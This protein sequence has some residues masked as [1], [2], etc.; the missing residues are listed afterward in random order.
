MNSPAGRSGHFRRP[1]AR[2]SRPSLE[3]A[4][5]GA[6]RWS[7][8]LPQASPLWRSSR[9]SGQPPSRTS[10]PSTTCA[11]RCRWCRA[12]RLRQRRPRRH[13]RRPSR[14]RLLRRRLLR[15][16]LFRRRCHLRR[17]WW[18][19]LRRRLQHPRRCRRRRIGDGS[20]MRPIT[21][22]RATTCIGTRPVSSR[23]LAVK[24][25]W[26]CRTLR[27]RREWMG[28]SR[29]FVGRRTARY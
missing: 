5:A 2:S 13:C 27:R 22:S 28:R 25:S 4:P 6:A 12:H 26:I 14:R 11:Q 23:L 18:W 17:L 15:R 20:R 8:L 21:R 9:S 19:C 3:P 10:A 16:S 29:S 24:T 1:L 7:V